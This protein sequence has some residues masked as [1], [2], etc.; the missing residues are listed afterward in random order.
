M[1]LAKSQ[2]LT[3]LGPESKLP[4]APVTNTSQISP[5]G[6]KCKHSLNQDTNCRSCRSQ[7]HLKSVPTAQTLRYR[8]PQTILILK[9]FKAEHM[10][11][12]TLVANADPIHSR[13]RKHYKPL[14][15]STC[16]R[17]H[18]QTQEFFIA[19]HRSPLASPMATHYM[20]NFCD[21]LTSRP[22]TGHWQFN[23]D[24]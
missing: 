4:L 7:T 23:C 3:F 24:A 6:H 8:N 16:Y 13:S 2:R 1:S 11:P 14:S 5:N 18:T 12:P 19:E 9:P 20:F 10:L 15:H 21:T 22:T 17:T